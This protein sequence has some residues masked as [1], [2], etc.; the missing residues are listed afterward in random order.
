VTHDIAVMQ[1]A[2]VVLAMTDGKL[3]SFDKKLL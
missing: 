1:K 3:Q 2:D